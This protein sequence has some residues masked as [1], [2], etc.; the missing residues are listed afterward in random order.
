[1]ASQA[2]P[3][4]PACLPS[5][6]RAG[7]VRAQS[8]QLWPAEDKGAAKETGPPTG[9]QEGLIRAWKHRSALDISEETPSFL[10]SGTQLISSGSWPS[11]SVPASKVVYSGATEGTNS[12]CLFQNDSHSQR[13]SVSALDLKWLWDLGWGLCD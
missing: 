5:S 8:L 11:K 3:R 2:E 12:S 6:P 10:P 13:K 4:L 1:M 9:P 7:F